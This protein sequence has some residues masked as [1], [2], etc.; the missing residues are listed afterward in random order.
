MLH[1]KLEFMSICHDMFVPN[2]LISSSTFWYVSLRQ[3]FVKC[4]AIYDDRTKQNRAE[5]LPYGHATGI[6]LAFSYLQTDD[7]EDIVVR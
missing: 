1:L 4:V 5:V 3:M 6:Y 2:E 7:I